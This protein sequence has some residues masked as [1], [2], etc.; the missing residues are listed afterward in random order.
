MTVLRLK[1]KLNL[2]AFSLPAPDREVTGGYSG[3][4]LSWVMGRA[5]IGQAWVTIMSNVNV[6]AVASLTEVAAVIMADGVVPDAD[7]LKR[8]E[9]QGINLLSSQLETF[10]LC[11]AISS[12]LN[13]G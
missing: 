10:E 12:V 1:E 8:A 5:R 3:D 11:A 9:E 6:V 4:L 7:A 13:E 2:S